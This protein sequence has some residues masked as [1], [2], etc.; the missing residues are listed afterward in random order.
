LCD[1]VMRSV[2]FWAPVE[3]GQTRFRTR[4]L[5]FD[6]CRIYMAAEFG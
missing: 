3:V 6:L 5:V 4:T 1:K 2:A